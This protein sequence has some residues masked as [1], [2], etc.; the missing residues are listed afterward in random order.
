MQDFKKA[1]K[2]QEMAI[3]AAKKNGLPSK[4]YLENLTRIKLK[5]L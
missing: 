4:V 2:I 1:T 5:T 3:S